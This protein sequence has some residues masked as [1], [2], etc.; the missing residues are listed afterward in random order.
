VRQKKNFWIML[1]PALFMTTVCSTYVFISPQMLHLPE[2]VGY[3]LGIACLIVAIVWFT[4][5]YKRHSNSMRNE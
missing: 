4:V 2:V 1:I 5:W 3:P